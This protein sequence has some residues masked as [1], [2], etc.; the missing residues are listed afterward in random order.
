MEAIREVTVWEGVS[1]QPNHTY[2]MDGD[3]AVAY[4]RWDE[5]TPF[6]FSKP[7]RLDKR[8]RKFVPAD[9]KLFDTKRIAS[10]VIKVTGSKGKVYS[11][12]PDAKTCSCP[13]FT[14]RGS[15]KH[16]EMV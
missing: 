16:L 1:R 3:K 12:D 14:F 6:Y 7:M 13:G 10:T 5:T 4:I 15:C 9:I 11:V 8:Y 2:L